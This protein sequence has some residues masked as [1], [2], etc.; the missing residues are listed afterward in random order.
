MI[1]PKNECEKV[2]QVLKDGIEILE[3]EFDYDISVLDVDEYAP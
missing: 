3:G 1:G 2:P